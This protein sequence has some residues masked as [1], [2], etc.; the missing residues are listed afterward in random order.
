MEQMQ[1]EDVEINDMFMIF[2]DF[3]IYFS[4]S[5]YVCLFL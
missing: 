2:G 5:L 1:R 3:F 4:L